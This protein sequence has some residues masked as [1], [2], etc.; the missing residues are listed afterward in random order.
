MTRN[1]LAR[2][3]ANS[4]RRQKLV[5]CQKFPRARK[6]QD[7]HFVKT[8]FLWNYFLPHGLPLPFCCFTSSYVFPT[9]LIAICVL[10]I[11]LFLC[12]SFVSFHVFVR[13]NVAVFAVPYV[14][15]CHSPAALVV[16]P[17]LRGT[18]I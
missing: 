16:I 14:L 3:Y 10:F 4:Q 7:G 13:V 15:E 6:G 2:D 11:D 18:I 8:F 12:F 1:Q 5:T 17:R 9:F